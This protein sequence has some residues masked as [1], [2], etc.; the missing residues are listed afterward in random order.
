MVYH[1]DEY[2]WDDPTQHISAELMRNEV[3][4]GTKFR[5]DSWCGLG[6]LNHM[7]RHMIST[8]F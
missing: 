7:T 3:P 5:K 8:P 4:G 6:L 1:A 2:E